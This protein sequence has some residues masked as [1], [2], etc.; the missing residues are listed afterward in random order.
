MVG[1]LSFIFG[2]MAALAGLTSQMNGSVVGKLLIF[3]QYWP[4]H[5]FQEEWVYNGADIDSQRVVW[6]RDLG[7]DNEKLIRYYGDRQVL[8]LEP[9]ARP[10]RLTAYA[11]P[12]QPEQVVA[13]APSE[14]PPPANG[15]N[16]KPLLELEQVR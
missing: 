7:P 3:V 9:D 10:P 11:P 8:L 4:Q 15:P 1:A 2:A 6:A 16:K 5:Q 14:T 12:E 13:P